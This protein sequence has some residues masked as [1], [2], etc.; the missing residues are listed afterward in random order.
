MSRKFTEAEI[1][2]VINEYDLGGPLAQMA[3]DHWSDEDAATALAAA[4]KQ[5]RISLEKALA[6]ATNKVSP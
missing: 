2:Q 4:F 5:E 3:F 1:G 6:V